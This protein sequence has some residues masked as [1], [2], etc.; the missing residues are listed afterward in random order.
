MPSQQISN[1][2]LPHVRT[3]H[4]LTLSSAFVEANI[5]LDLFFKSDFMWSVLDR[6]ILLM[7]VMHKCLFTDFLN[8]KVSDSLVR[9]L[10]FLL[11]KLVTANVKC[12][13]QYRCHRTRSW[14]FALV[15]KNFGWQFT[16]RKTVTVTVTF[17]DMT[18]LL[19]PCKCYRQYQCHC[20]HMEH[21]CISW[22]PRSLHFMFHVSNWVRLFVFLDGDSD[23]WF[24]IC[25]LW[26]V[27][28]E[29]WTVQ[30]D[31]CIGQLSQWT[32]S[33]WGTLR[34]EKMNQQQKCFI[35][36]EKFTIHKKNSPQNHSTI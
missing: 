18:G 19:V 15:A 30:K 34:T 35:V 14:V 31:S 20:H 27:I 9:F 8:W 21:R 32:N 6:V 28:C 12:Y 1:A 2:S 29:L 10:N 22:F 3:Y 16:E 25:G 5:Y 11:V 26:S 17:R 36:F 7:L 24:V 33:F 13:R 23:L 4:I